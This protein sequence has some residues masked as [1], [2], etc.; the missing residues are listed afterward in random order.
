[1]DK[2]FIC[3]ANSYKRGGR[4][5][6]GVEISYNTLDEWS[7]V[8]NADGTPRWIRPTAANTM[9]GEI[10]IVDAAKIKYFSIVKL[11]DV[12]PCPKEIHKEDVYYSL[13]SV[14]GTVSPSLNVLN[15]FVDNFH[16]LI[17]FN[18]GRAIPVDSN[19]F[20]AYSLMFIHPEKVCTY[21]DSSWEKPKTRMKI[22]YCGSIYDF[23]VTDP[24]FLDEYR[25]N[26][27]SHNEDVDYYLTLSLG[28]EFEG[29]HHKLVAAVFKDIPLAKEEQ[30]ASSGKW[31]IKEER[32][33]TEEESNAVRN[34]IVVA[35]QIGKSVCFYMK[36][37]G[38]SFIPLTKDSEIGVGENVIVDDL[39]LLTLSR[40]GDDDIMRVRYCKRSMTYMDQQKQLHNNAY[41]KWTDEDDRLLIQLYHNGTSIKELMDKFGRNEGAIMSRLMNLEAIDTDSQMPLA[42][43]N[44][45]P[46]SKTFFGKIKEFFKKDNCL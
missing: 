22:T 17:F 33:F 14:C 5:I 15:Q 9:F 8:R 30:I 3:L 35:N 32:N 12:T 6:A 29:W 19:F 38:Q 10:P 21:I 39:Q 25:E 7:V 28:L 36:A 27:D 40:V 43:N 24:Y 31:T 18:H 34:A 20:N 1:M 42:T 41:V 2:Y 11:T 37:G 13:I 23:P 45:Q 4:C 44:M 26:V 46:K 16:K